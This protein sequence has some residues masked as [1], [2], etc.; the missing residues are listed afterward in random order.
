MNNVTSV[1]FYRRLQINNRFRS[2][3]AMLTTAFLMV[4]TA[5]A[6]A[7][8]KDDASQ[9]I[10][11]LSATELQQKIAVQ[12]ITA[13]EAVNA[14]LLRIAELDRDGPQV[15]SIIALNPQALKIAS[16]RDQEAKQGKLRGPLHGVPVL[17]KDN[18]E[19]S[20]MPTTAGSLAL[21]NNHTKRD[22]PIIQRLKEAGAIILG[23]TNLSEWA[24][25]RDE[26]SVSGWSAVGG[27]TRNPHSLD[28]TPCGSSSGTGAAIAAHF[29]PLGI[30]TETNGSII[31]PSAM[32]G[33]VGVKPT[34]GLLSRTH[35]VPI[36]VTQDT[37][38]PMTRTVKD[39][40]LMLSVMA[41]SDT[42]DPATTLADKNKRNYVEVLD[43]PLKGK[44]I[45]VFRA[46]QSDHKEIVDA[47]DEAVS[48]LESQGVEIV[49]IDKY[50]TP[51]G[52]WPKATQ[53][54]LIEFKHELNKYLSQAAPDVEVR[55]LEQLIA[56]NKANEREL[57]IFG[58]SLF[59]DAQATQGYNEDY[60]ELLRFLQQST[61]KDGIDKL[62]K[63]YDVD[64][65]MMPSQTPA[66]LI[67]PIYGDSFPGGFAGAG[68]M[69]AIAGY[70]QVSVPMG[71]MRGLPVN[72]SFMG[73]AWD[74]ATLLNIAY[75]YE[76]ASN[77]R[78]E[79]ELA[80]GSF[81]HSQFK[82]AMK[83]LDR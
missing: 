78:I 41:G 40:A 52:F 16:E 25:F 5:N 13:V 47:L 53:L 60:K 39:A 26:D 57:A 42:T 44:R 35:I 24:N 75:Q 71:S 55:S 3:Q 58:Q 14:Y 30:G 81:E 51:E 4:F 73:T 74:E 83:A 15:Q 23:K 32:N 21:I 70:P 29:S 76:Q 68:W 33:I 31:C 82:K 43:T 77:K 10:T 49:E 67:D 45:A 34:V 64:A 66:F 63:E 27:Q 54:L 22:A 12:E 7:L 18:I 36:S 2:L 11:A 65:V 28:R 59:I 50:E 1:P 80:S 8:N 37:A 69:A 20:N 72:V 19:T 9:D 6:F 79:P 17:V 61:R 46:V 38:G 62:L 56:F 48:V